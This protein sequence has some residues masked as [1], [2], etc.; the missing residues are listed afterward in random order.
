MRLILFSTLLALSLACA[1]LAAPSAAQSTTATDG[2]LQSTPCPMEVNVNEA[3]IKEVSVTTVTQGDWYTLTL[4]NDD[5]DAAHTIAIDGMGVTLTAGA[6]ADSSKDVHFTTVGT[7]AIKETPKGTTANVE[8]IKG[9][10]VDHE[11]GLDSSSAGKKMP[12]VDIGLLVAGLAALAAVRRRL[13]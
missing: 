6:L 12:G 2:C 10:S 11:Q 3:G 9:D 4:S 5:P 13:A 7:F 8:V 1:A